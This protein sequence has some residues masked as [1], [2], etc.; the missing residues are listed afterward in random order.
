MTRGAVVAP[1]AAVLWCWFVAEPRPVADKQ[2]NAQPTT[3]CCLRYIYRRIVSR[4]NTL[5]HDT[6]RDAILTCAR[7]PTWVSLIYPDG[8]AHWALRGIEQC[9]DPPVCLS[10]AFFILSS[11]LPLVSGINSGSPRQPR[12]SLA[13]SDSPGPIS[14]TLPT[15][16]SLGLTPWIPWTVYRYFWAYPFFF[17]L[18]FLF[19]TVSFPRCR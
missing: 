2:T 19:S 17:S 7:K 11:M 13:N 16:S 15:I 8:P 12:T 4:K 3:D 1:S 9:C 6:I 10:H 18:L 5:H 14:G